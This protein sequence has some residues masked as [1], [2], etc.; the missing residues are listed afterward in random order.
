VTLGTA[1]FAV[2]LGIGSGIVSGMLGVG[3]GVVMIP[4]LV[5]ALGMTQHV[6]EGTSLLVIIPTAVVGSF[7][8][9]RRGYVMLLTAAIIGAGGIGGALAGSHLALA[10][11]GR[12]LRIVF[13]VYLILI[14]LRMVVPSRSGREL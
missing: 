5:L 13:V 4:G 3:G 8:L 6:A 11:P 2:A 9:W 14:G 7:T 12:T 10:V 1:L